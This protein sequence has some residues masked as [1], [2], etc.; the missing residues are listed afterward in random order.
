MAEYKTL[1]DAL[2]AV[3]TAV[4]DTLNDQPQLKTHSDDV[5]HDM[6][7]AIAWDCEPDVAK[8][9]SRVTGVPLS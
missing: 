7:Q 6:V 8:E 9:L 5:Y 2:L 4:E 1:E 3:D